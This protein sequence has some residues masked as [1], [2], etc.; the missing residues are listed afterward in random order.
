MV[1]W[2]DRELVPLA[3]ARIDPTDR[4]FTLGDGLYETLRVRRGR[5]ERVAEHLARLARGARLLGIPL[6]IDDRALTEA[7]A[8]TLAANGIVD[9]VLRL[10]LTRGPSARGLALPANPRPTLL[11]TAVAPSAPLPPA[12]LIIAAC[13]RRNER[14]PL[15]QVK[16]LGALDGLLARREAVA[17]G[18]D[19]AL[20]LNG[21]G[22]TAEA[23][24]ANVFAC[25]DG[26][27]VTPPLDDGALP[28]VARAAILELGAAR[29]R[30][31]GPA[32]L[33]RATE[34]FLSNSLGLRAVSRIEGKLVAT[35]H[36]RPAMQELR[37]L[38]FPD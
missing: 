6:P 2:L 27:L 34:V 29:E 19:D 26:Q 12:S 1:V 10:T 28:G 5:P 24:V 20:L 3:D 14:S 33:C 15:A 23:T 22:R 7:L 9:G 36:E 37:A 11:L 17:R 35:G 32:E 31:F 38:L 8:A 25:I 21:A 13:T 16:A 18:A 30:S 4:G